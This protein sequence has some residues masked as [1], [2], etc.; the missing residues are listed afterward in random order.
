MTPAL[1]VL[2]GADGALTTIQAAARLGVRTICVDARPEAPGARAADEYLHLSTHDVD[3]I[4]RALAGRSDL[5]GVVSPASDVN[6]PHQA[7]LLDRLGLP[8]DLSPG[9]VRASV[10]KAYVRR[11][12]DELGLP[13]PRHVAGTAEDVL[14]GADRLRWPVMVKPVDLGG[15]RGVV[16]C[17]QPD[18]LADAV[19]AAAGWSPTGQVLVEE[20]VTGA[21]LGMEA[22]LVDGEVRLL[23]V[24]E[25]VLGPAPAFATLGHDMG[26]ADP[27]LLAAARTTV[28][29]L[30]A[31]LGYRRGFLNADLVWTGHE[32]VLIELGARLGGNGVSELLGLVNDVDSTA[33]YVRLALG[34]DV[35]AELTGLDPARPDPSAEVRR[36]AAS[37]VL[38]ADEP[39]TLVALDG[40]AEAMEV[41]GVADLVVAAVPG[42]HVE[43]YTQCRNKLGFVLVVAADP[44]EVDLALTEVARTVR[45]RVTTG[46]TPPT[47]DSTGP[48]HD[49][50]GQLVG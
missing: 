16:R 25:R 50:V 4:V 5:R 31:E 11:L 17:E 9:A 20:F 18:A 28:E 21:D 45:A 30:C 29:R 27:R 34:E 42:D 49:E 23:G 7:A 1:L 13:G 15:G 37:R 47:G 41:P 32:V 6:V 12:C 38:H 24:S 46:A 35:D 43:P 26:A 44:V 22:V 19:H 2:G 39:G 48:T 3:A 33:L 14:A 8:S 10:D 40:L 36:Y